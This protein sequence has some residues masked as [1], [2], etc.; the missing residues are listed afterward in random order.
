M[1]FATVASAATTPSPFTAATVTQTSAGY[2]VSWRSDATKVNVFATHDRAG[3]AGAIKVGSGGGS[4]SLTVSGLTTSSGPYSTSSRWYFRL[5]T[6]AGRSVVVA[7]R[8]VHVGG[9]PNFRDL[10]GY[11]TTSGRWVKEG[12]LFRSA[13][14]S[15]ITTAGV[16]TVTQLGIKTD[17]DLRTPSEDA[18]HPDPVIPG[19]T[20]VADSINPDGDPEISDEIPGLSDAASLIEMGYAFGCYQS[21]YLEFGSN[22]TCVNGDRILFHDILAAHGSPLLFHCTFG[23]DRTGWA[24]YVLL[25]ILGVPAATAMRDYLASNFYNK[26]MLQSYQTYYLNLNV[27]FTQAQTD[28]F[29]KAAY[30]HAAMTAVNLTYGSFTRYVHLG[31]GLTN[32]QIQTLRNTY[33]A[34]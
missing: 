33:L 29:L 21:L 14:F 9:V 31:L 16:T 10:G 3:V 6:P 32:S 30:I 12:L 17:I 23:D 28:F 11:R 25:R 5:T 34:S 27:G 20:Y 1:L 13:R 15:G 18:A 4:G 8:H 19:I 2:K 24:S 26:A 7:V 22:A